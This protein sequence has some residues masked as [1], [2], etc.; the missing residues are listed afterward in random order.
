MLYGVSSSDPETYVTAVLG[1]MA[2]AAVA[3]VIPALRA[4]RIDPMEAL[5]EE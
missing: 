4:A 5:R 3:S 1:L 2:V